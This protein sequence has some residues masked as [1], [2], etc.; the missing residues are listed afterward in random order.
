MP[1]NFLAIDT[2]MPNLGGNGSTDDKFKA[3]QSYLYMLLENLRYGLRNLSPENFNEA[4]TAEWIKGTIRAE[5]I[6]ADELYSNY[7]AIADLTVDKVRTDYI[8]AEKYLYSDTTPI[9]YI[10]IYD[11]VIQL[12]T[13]TVHLSGT[14]PTPDEEQLNDN[15]RYFYWTDTSYSS[16]TFAKNTGLPV[17]VYKY[18]EQVKLEI[19]F[20]P[21]NNNGTIIKLPI[22]TIGA[23]S[24]TGNKGKAFIY[25]HATGLSV[26]YCQDD[27]S[28]TDTFMRI[29][30]TDSGIDVYGDVEF[31]GDVQFDGYVNGD[32]YPP[33]M[34]EPE[35]PAQP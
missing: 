21:Y 10:R 1:S 23:G 32:V 19:A 20:K 30:M 31:H 12:I 3:V 27:Y 18:D 9:D 24:G 8:R 25:K 35:T 33:P 4:E 28:S 29:E 7:G 2:G 17:Y 26:E 13:G 14:P 6:V 5:T 16:M 11:D 15:G 34:P 22:I